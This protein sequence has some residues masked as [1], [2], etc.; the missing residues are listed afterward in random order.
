MRS[1]AKTDRIF[2]GQPGKLPESNHTQGAAAEEQQGIHRAP[3]TRTILRGR[4][5]QGTGRRSNRS[6]HSQP[7]S[8]SREKACHPAPPRVS[9]VVSSSPPPKEE[10][11][12]PGSKSIHNSHQGPRMLSSNSRRTRRP[13]GIRA[14]TRWAKENRSRRRTSRATTSN[15]RLFPL[16]RVATRQRI[17]RT[18]NRQEAT[19]PT[20]WRA[21]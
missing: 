20:N 6:S 16:A 21:W 11:S 13:P 7:Q 10:A 17:Q 18:S 1:A 19:H 15:H 2:L 9:A 5:Q 4:W 3:P 8:S 12:S 14:R